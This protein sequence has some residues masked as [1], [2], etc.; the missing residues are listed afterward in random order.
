MNNHFFLA[1]LQFLF[2]WNV[3]SD[4]G[5]KYF[6]LLQPCRKSTC[7]FEI[8]E[9]YGDLVIGLKQSLAGSFFPVKPHVSPPTGKF[10][11][12]AKN[13]L[14]EFQKYWNVEPTGN[15]V[16]SATI[17]AFE[18]ALGI[19]TCAPPVI[20][21]LP[22]KNIT[23]EISDGALWVLKNYAAHPIGTLIPFA[24]DGNH[25]FGR[26]ELHFHPWNGTM[27]PYGY[28]HGISVYYLVE[29]SEMTGS[30]FMSRTTNM[31]VG[32]RE[33]M[34]LLELTRNHIP[35]IHWN[36]VVVQYEKNLFELDVAS[37]YLSIGT[38]KD[39]IRIPMGSHT[40]QK[41]LDLYNCS[42]PTTLLVDEIWK[43]AKYQIEPQP[44]PPGP[45]MVSNAY[46][47]HENNL[48]NNEMGHT[49][50]YTFTG[51]QKKDLVITNQFKEHPKS[52]AIY[53]WTRLNGQNIQPLYL[54]HACWYADY[55]HGLRMIQNQIL[56]NGAPYLI[57][58]ALKSPAY[59]SALSREGVMPNPKI[60]EC[61]IPSAECIISW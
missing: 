52:T 18:K 53:G 16:G 34:I 28:H 12:N 8:G 45:E 3:A 55:S 26:V 21:R 14:I 1:I 11:D 37:D 13:S 39:F 57:E 42:A 10:T 50:W 47:I 48:I 49:P 38:E 43:Q 17:D 22:Y 19:R 24:A 61:P 58:D 20:E 59:A 44:L 51:G 33:T 29:E 56:I 30:E 25:Y 41:I 2:I 4:E 32:Q 46:F 40:T 15:V 60:P 6:H 36:K 54:G 23:A 31:S 5:P 27:T 9:D 7:I 35:Q